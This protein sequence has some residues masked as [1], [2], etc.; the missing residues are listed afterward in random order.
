MFLFC[1]I[2]LVYVFIFERESMSTEVARQRE[3]E[4]QAGSTLSEPDVGLKPTE[5]RDHDL[6]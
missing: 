5:P 3:R 2:F 4:S 1:G 6:A